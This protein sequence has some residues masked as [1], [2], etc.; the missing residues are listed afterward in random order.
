MPSS[1]R[2]FLLSSAAI[3]AQ[4]AQNQGAP[5]DRINVAIVGLHG[6][7]R[8]HIR[9]FA[10]IPNVRVA[11]LC[12]VDERLFPTSVAEVE[13]LGGNRPVTE[14]DMR[15]LLERKDIDAIAIAT[16]DYWHALQTIWSCQAGKDVYVEKPVSFTVLEGRRMV[17]AARKYKRIVQAGLNR[18]SDATTRAAIDQLHQGKFGR[19]YRAKVDIVRPRANIGRVQESSIPPGV[20][21]DLFL[22]PSP[23][24]PYTANRFHY[25]WHYF[26]ETGP[27]DVGNIG[28]HSLDIA[29]WGLKRQTHPTK[30]HS[31]G[32]LYVF[33]SDQETPNYQVGTFE[34]PDRMILNFEHNN[35]YS[36]PGHGTVFFTSEGYVTD[37]WKAFR[38]SFRPRN[39]THPAGIDENVMNASFPDA[40]YTQLPAIEPSAGAV[41][42]FENFVNAMRTRRVEDL[43]CDIFEGHLS[44]SLALLARISMTTGRKLTF[45]PPT[46]TFPGDSEADALLTRKY[47]EP[48]TLPDR[49]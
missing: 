46:E 26:H 13:K 24:R 47:R 23:Y 45:D 2:Q 15:R 12:D 14:V 22:G 44:T 19:P 17:E 32:G 41:S 25:G 37:E 43:Y 6:R 36:P 3:G 16:P 21:W 4:A 29:R 27:T 1:R 39:R 31:I 34:Y 11:A 10:R 28:T 7:G 49:V 9:A 18:R 40:S 20:H 5:S 35:L 48:Y 42:H 33:D 8:D 30:I 38:G